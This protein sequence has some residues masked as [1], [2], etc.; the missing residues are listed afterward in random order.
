MNYFR[1][2][3]FWIFAF[4]TSFSSAASIQLLNATLEEA[5]AYFSNLTG[6]SYIID[7]NTEKRFIVTRDD[8]DTPE[9]FHQLFIELITNAEAQI[10]KK[11]EK[12]FVIS[13][14]TPEIETEKEVKDQPKLIFKISLEGKMTFKGLRN[15]LATMVDL[16]GVKIIE[17]K[18]DTSSVIL[19][20]DTDSINLLKLLLASLPSD[21]V[22][23]ETPKAIVQPQQQPKIQEVETNKE[24]VRVVDLNY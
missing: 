6:N 17:E 12:S 21:P 15:L 2:I 16:N 1:L 19:L 14:P 8:L 7:F 20:G 4:W 5:A 11:A 9:Q 22:K 13:K 10:E 3:C 23:K 18:T 24:I